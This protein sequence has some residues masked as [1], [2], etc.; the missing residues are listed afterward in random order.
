MRR[1]AGLTYEG[2]VEQTGIAKTT[3]RRKI[4]RPGTLTLDEAFAIGTAIGATP[5]TWFEIAS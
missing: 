2:L 4:H 3:I 5:D 1:T